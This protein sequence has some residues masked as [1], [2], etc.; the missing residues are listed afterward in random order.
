[1]SNP[2]P[3]DGDSI[4]VVDLNGDLILKVRC[5]NK[6]CLACSPNPEACQDPIPALPGA[7]PTPSLLNTVMHSVM[8]LV[9]GKPA[10]YSVHRVRGQALT[11]AVVRL[12]QGRVDL[13]PVFTNQKKGRYKVRFAAAESG[14]RTW[15]TDPV[16]VE[17]DPARDSAVAVS[18]LESG[19]YSLVLLES[20]SSD[21]SPVDTWVLVASPDDY[22][23]IASAFADISEQTAKWGTSVRRDTAQ[24]FLRASLD[25]LATQQSAGSTRDGKQ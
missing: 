17:W 10:R 3:A 15:K 19:L 22:P 6:Q 8:E 7:K 2:Y 16:S 14:G 11:D 20:E 5:Q 25:Y 1:L 13:A 23:K 4:T 18:G 24:G 9:K 21:G 12:D